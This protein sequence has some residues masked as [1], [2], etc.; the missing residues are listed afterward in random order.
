MRISHCDLT[1]RAALSTAAVEATRPPSI[2]G[3]SN[4]ARF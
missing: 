1:L 4:V 3:V 2:E